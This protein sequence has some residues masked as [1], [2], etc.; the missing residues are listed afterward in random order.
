MPAETEKRT[1][2]RTVLQT[3]AVGTKVRVREDY[4]VPPEF[5][6]VHGT[7]KSRYG[8]IDYRA[9]EVLLDIGISEL[10]WQHEL[11]EV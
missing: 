8:V 7:I 11:E 10:F 9:F 2:N 4:R 6:G 1:N 3:D 5:W